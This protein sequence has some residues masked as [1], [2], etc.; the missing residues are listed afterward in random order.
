MFT[1]VTYNVLAQAYIKPD[2]YRGVD[3][4]ALA[5]E[6]RRRRLLAQIAGLDADVVCLQEVEPDLFDALSERLVDHRG[7]HAPKPGRP[8]GCAVFVRHLTCS[9]HQVVHYDACE[10]GYPH[11]GQ[12]LTLNGDGH[13]FTVA[14]TH[15]RWQGREVPIREHLGLKQF[16]ELVR[17]V[18]PEHP[19]LILGDF[20][21]LSQSPV[22]AEASAAGFSLAGRRLRPWDTALINGRRRKLDYVLYE[23][24]ALVA[25]PE[26]LR[27][28]SRDTPI[29]SLEV[30]SDHLPLRVEFVWR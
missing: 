23:E 18:P 29:P 26:P 10:A 19:R 30:P 25:M 7:F 1:V 14:N 5:A 17:A 15:L 8:D 2:R 3:P 13:T 21:A 22:L 11:L 24:G 16:V 6:P 20:N 9:D 12:I 27:P 4:A 28:L